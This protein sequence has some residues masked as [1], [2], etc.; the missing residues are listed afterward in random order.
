MEEKEKKEINDGK[1][2]SKVVKHK[3]GNFLLK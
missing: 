3:K 2:T 1:K